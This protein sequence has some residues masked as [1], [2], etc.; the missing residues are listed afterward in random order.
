VLGW[1]EAFPDAEIR[2]RNLVACREYV[3]VELAVR[4]THFSPL[5]LLDVAVP[6][7]FR[8]IELQVCDVYTVAEGLIIGGRSY[9]DVAS[10]VRQLKPL[11]HSQEKGA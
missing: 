1:D 2:V 10:L 9:W 11:P 5:I 3:V 4:G 6:P 7:T 8:T